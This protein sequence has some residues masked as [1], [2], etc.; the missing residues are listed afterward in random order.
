MKKLRYAV[1][2]IPIIALPFSPTHAG[3]DE[4][5][6]ASAGKIRVLIVT[7]GHDFDGEAFFAIFNNNPDVSYRAVQHPNAQAFFRPEAAS[8]YDVILAYDNYQQISEQA[9]ADFANLVKGGKGLV[10]VHHGIGSYLDW[11]EFW[12]IMGARWYHVKTIVG[13]VEKFSFP[14]DT[15]DV[16]FRVHVVDPRN[17]VTKGMSDYDMIDETYQA[18]DVFPDS[19]PLLSTDS[20]LSNKIIAW[21]KTYGKGRVVC[22][23]SGHGPDAYV[24]PNFQQ[25]LR[26]TIRWTG[27]RD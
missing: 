2:L 12:K 24:N 16:R 5:G 27:R 22:I 3:P 9:K 18:F 15:N 23:Q 20:P 10:V 26:Q 11:P 21:E 13:G 7:G 14:S 8:Q 25:F 4:P 19:H 17:P 1:A 6:P